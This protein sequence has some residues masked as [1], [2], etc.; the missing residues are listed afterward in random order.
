MYSLS[1][2][3]FQSI[4][5]AE[6]NF[7]G[8]SVICGKSN[9]GKSA[10]RRA[11]QT[12]LLYFKCQIQNTKELLAKCDVSK[13]IVDGM[14]QV[15]VCKTEFVANTKYHDKEN[16]KTDFLNWIDKVAD[17]VKHTTFIHKGFKD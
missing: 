9:L 1:I 13:L 2:N 8:F 7:E 6:F 15:E 10:I 5:K 16:L 17:F 3:N 4:K 11:L 14:I 12:I